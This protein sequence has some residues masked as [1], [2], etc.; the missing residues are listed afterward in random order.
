MN[1]TVRE[2]GSEKVEP[3]AMNLAHQARS[4]QVAKRKKFTPSS[5]LVADNDTSN[6][7]SL[8]KV[9][10]KEGFTAI[11]ASDGREAR[12]MLQD[13]KDI[14]AAIFRPVIPHISGPDLVRYM[15]REE[16][17]RDIPVM[18]MTADS[19]K[20]S[21][22]GLAAGAVVLLPEPFSP[23]QVQ[24]LLHMLVDTSHGAN[25]DRI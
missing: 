19:I 15:R 20:I 12:K 16:H 10:E 14:V 8:T 5:V 21:C 1:A 18:M 11:V 17:L 25:Q 22:E 6:L 23:S 3:G 7:F 24:H 4:T 2:K 9:I 13:R